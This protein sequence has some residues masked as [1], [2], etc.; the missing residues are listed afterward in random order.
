MRF[1]KLFCLVIACAMVMGCLSVEAG[2]VSEA[3]PSR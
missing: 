3:G 2:A 1:K